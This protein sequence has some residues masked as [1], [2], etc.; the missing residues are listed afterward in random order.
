MGEQG[1]LE[2]GKR[3]RRECKT[4]EGLDV[5]R[6]GRAG[7]REG[8]ASR[9]EELARR[10]G[11]G[12][13]R[14]MRHVGGVDRLR[15]QWDERG[16]DDEYEGGQEDDYMYENQKEGSGEARE[17]ARGGADDAMEGRGAVE[18]GGPG[19]ATEGGEGG[20]RRRGKRKVG[21]G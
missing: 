18:G 6:R 13:E 16:V 12:L 10:V 1:R 17:T 20:R 11:R 15:E 19:D 7:A 4:A 9:I 14:D 2:A 5:A 21:D 3:R 8:V